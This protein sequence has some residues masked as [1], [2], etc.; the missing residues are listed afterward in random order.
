MLLVIAVNVFAHVEAL[1]ADKLVLQ[2]ITI[3]RIPATGC[4]VI[5]LGPV[6]NRQRGAHVAGLL[7]IANAKLRRAGAGQW[8]AARK[9]AYCTNAATP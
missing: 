1:P 7:Q 5:F 4:A 8:R 6:A 3:S 9:K 2:R